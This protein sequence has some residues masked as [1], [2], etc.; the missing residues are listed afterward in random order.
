MGANPIIVHGGGKEISKWMKKVDK[1][2]VFIDGLRVTDSETMELTEMV[3]SGKINNEVVSLINSQGGK[4][5]GLSGKD[6][7][8][9][10]AKKIRSKKN[11]DLGQVGE[12]EKMDLSIAKTI[13]EKGYIPVISSIG[14]SAVGESLNLNAD[15]V[16][17]AAAVCLEA[18]KL[19]YLTDVMGVSIAGNLQQQINATDATK[20]LEGNEV[21]GGMRPKLECCIQAS[22]RGVRDVHI[23]NG[24]I[25]HSLLLEVLTDGGIGTMIS[26]DG[27]ANA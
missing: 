22:N 8:M 14:V 26:R 2:A 6:A 10:S 7:N 27:K 19:V 5:V 3:L 11:E 12:V 25:E 23:I 1:E 20:L 13:S 16:A 9:F 4:A 21:T 15:N 24:T 18:R 17:A